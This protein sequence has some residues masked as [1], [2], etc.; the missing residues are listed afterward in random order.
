MQMPTLE[1]VKDTLQ[2]S[3]CH[4]AKEAFSDPPVAPSNS[5][6]KLFLLFSTLVFFWQQDWQAPQGQESHLS[7][8]LSFP[9]STRAQHI[10]GTQH[11]SVDWRISAGGWGAKPDLTLGQTS[12][13]QPDHLTGHTA[14]VCTTPLLVSRCHW[15][16]PP[17]TT[18]PLSFP[19]LLSLLFPPFFLHS[20]ALLWSTASCPLTNGL[21]AIT[22]GVI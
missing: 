15:G 1:G 5:P 21:T 4:L 13:R 7:C 11:R 10:K 19:S 20:L 17:P 3:C 16:P 18:V 6:L 14:P 12:L 8:P 9:V 22:N 2:V